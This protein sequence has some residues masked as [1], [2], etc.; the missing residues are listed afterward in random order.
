[1]LKRVNAV[2]F[3]ADKKEDLADIKNP[4]M[5]ME[6]FVIEEAV[7]YRCTSEGKWIKQIKEVLSGEAVDLAD[8]ATKEEVADAIEESGANTFFGEDP[9]VLSKLGNAHFGLVIN[10]DDNTTIADALYAK[11]FGLYTLWVGKGNPDLP[12]AVLEK[13]SSVRG[14]C[15]M[16]TDNDGAWYGWINIYDHDGYM[17]SRY[18]RSGVPTE[19]RACFPTV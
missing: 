17:Y 1:M 10:K 19:W 13:N 11:G 5:G 8:Y 12:A 16:D 2:Y 9:E 4:A 3:L 18:I 14:L 7:E 15:C 6:C